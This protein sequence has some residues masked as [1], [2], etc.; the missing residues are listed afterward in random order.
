MRQDGPSSH[1]FQSKE[2][3]TTV[4]PADLSE[5]WYIGLGQATETLKVTT[6]QLLRSAILPLVRQYHADQMYTRP[7]IWGTIYTD[8]MNSWY[9][10][11]DGN[12]HAQVFMNES[13]F[14]ATYPMEKKATTGQALK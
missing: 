1:T 13:F 7:R 2:Q 5:R 3:H 12:K 8:T 6:Q 11:L 4:T 9:K 10:S 14:T